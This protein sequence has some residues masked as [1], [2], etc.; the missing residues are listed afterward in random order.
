MGRT[1]SRVIQN[2]STHELN[3]YKTSVARITDERMSTPDENVQV[4]DYA[5]NLK[6]SAD[7]SIQVETMNI[8]IKETT[9]KNG[10]I[11]EDSYIKNLVKKEI[12]RVI[13]EFMEKL[14][15]EQLDGD[16]REAY[17]NT[18]KKRSPQTI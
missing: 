7:I 1:R 13:E 3:L 10:T 12:S 5:N 15:D 11:T 6:D 17:T 14:T 8:N 9:G 16:S 4:L 2:T 18:V